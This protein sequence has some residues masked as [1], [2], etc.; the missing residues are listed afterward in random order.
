MDRH[1]GLRAYNRELLRVFSNT[2]V[3]TAKL[4]GFEVKSVL[5]PENYRDQD[6]GEAKLVI[7]IVSEN[8]IVL[9]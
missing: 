2:L 6:D 3:A 4:L 7:E 5:T 8:Q 1:G 9:K